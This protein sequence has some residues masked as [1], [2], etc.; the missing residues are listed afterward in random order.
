M[1]VKREWRLFLTCFQAEARVIGLPQQTDVPAPVPITLTLLP[2]VLQT[3]TSS[4]LLVNFPPPS[5]ATPI[6]SF[7]KSGEIFLSLEWPE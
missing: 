7:K 6:N 4:S 5:P 3:Y 2:Q 1:V